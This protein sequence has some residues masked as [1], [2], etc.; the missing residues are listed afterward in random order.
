MFFHTH[1]YTHTHTYTQTKAF[2]GTVGYSVVNA[3]I[4]DARGSI[5]GTLPVGL[6]LSAVG[7]VLSPVLSV[8]QPFRFRV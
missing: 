3:S 6:V 7:L 5:S 4:H 2:M 1:P 8:L